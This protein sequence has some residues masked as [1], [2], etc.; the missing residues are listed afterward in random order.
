MRLLM[1]SPT[2]LG[3]N[4]VVPPM[5]K[6]PSVGAL[7]PNTAVSDATRK[8]QLRASASPSSLVRPLIA[9][10]VS[11]GYLRNAAKA[12][13][14]SRPSWLREA[15]ASVSTESRVPPQN[16]SAPAPVTTR[17]GLGLFRARPP[18]RS[19]NSSSASPFQPFSG[20][21]SRV[22][23]W[24]CSGAPGTVSETE[25]SLITCR[26]P[27]VRRSLYSHLWIT[28]DLPAPFPL[29]ELRL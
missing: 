27:P 15:R 18:S 20:G 2:S 29:A 23:N 3:S 1:D 25:L 7:I 13:E 8:S 14:Y 12:L 16:H 9:A 22:S 5:G 11:A 6:R 28:T 4:W 24:I 10:T 26:F 21:E 19:C 17:G